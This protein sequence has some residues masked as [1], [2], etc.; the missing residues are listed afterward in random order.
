MIPCKREGPI[1]PEL[2][3]HNGI[4]HSF[5]VENPV[6]YAQGRKNLENNGVQIFLEED[7]QGEGV[8]GLRPCFRDL[9]VTVLEYINLNSYS[10]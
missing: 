9:G 6:A 2:D 1:N 5:E 10:G 7:R 4:H 8:N 3:D